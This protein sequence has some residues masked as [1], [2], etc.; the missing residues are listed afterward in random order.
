[1]TKH[2]SDKP[3]DKWNVNDFVKYFDDQHRE[4]FGIPYEPMRGWQA[5]R[6]VIA[7]AVGTAKREGAYPKAVVKEFIDECLANYKPTQ[8]YPGTSFMFLYTYRKTELQRILVSHNQRSKDE[9]QAE[10]ITK[11]K[12][13]IAEWFSS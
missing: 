11:N 4:Q 5:E 8:Q 9:E 7:G 10:E 6:G 1:M 13:D 2:Y 3:I 12:A